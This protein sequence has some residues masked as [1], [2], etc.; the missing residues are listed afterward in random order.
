[1]TWGQ[2][3]ARCAAP[4]G[5][6]VGA[7][8]PRRLWVFVAALFVCGC[9]GG[10]LQAA[11]APHYHLRL[12]AAEPASSVLCDRA[13]EVEST[14]QPS[15]DAIAAGRD[16]NC[17]PV[18]SQTLE[19]P[20]QLTVTLENAT[21]GQTYQLDYQETHSGGS[22]AAPQRVIDE[23]V[24]RLTGFAM[25]GVSSLLDGAARTDP[26]AQG[27][28]RLG[29]REQVESVAAM[30]DGEL[31]AR[32]AAATQRVLPRPPAA[33]APPL[34]YE[35]LVTQYVEDGA[36]DTSE[37]SFSEQEPPFAR[38][39]RLDGSA[40]SLLREGGRSDD[41]VAAFVAA[42]CRRDGW[43]PLVPENDAVQ[44]LAYVSP[45]VA[46]ED[47][48]GALGLT[49][50]A[51]A[52]VLGGDGSFSIGQTI[53]ARYGDAVGTLRRGSVPEG[54]VRAVHQLAV[55][56]RLD[57]QLGVCL[58]NIDY[59]LANAT[60]APERTAAL[61]AARAEVVALQGSTRD[62]AQLYAATI[63]PFVSE[64]AATYV[65]QV[66]AE[67]PVQLGTYALRGGEVSLAVRQ[68][69]A[70]PFTRH[71]FAVREGPWV[72]V[73][74][75][76]VVTFCAS[77]LTRVEQQALPAVGDGENPETPTAA[78][79]VIRQTAESAGVAMAISLHL[80][81]FRFPHVQLGVMLGYPIGDATG[82]AATGLLGASL[83]I[84][85]IG[86]QI[87]VGA[88]FFEQRSMRA[89]FGTEVD[90]SLPDNAYLTIDAVSQTTIGVAGFAMAGVSFDVL[91]NL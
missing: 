56:A 86:L 22:S 90:L 32:I 7:A 85:P 43:G 29:G 60:L 81:V 88:Q 23:F 66:A 76:P 16:V 75:G 61:A 48:I 52:G 1:M 57:R 84:S 40:A 64:L 13:I 12:N 3:V 14:G 69:G 27:L 67:A 4:G 91:N 54:T 5:P 68:Q 51:L 70:E 73:S 49:P 63:L 30:L 26:A 78:R 11:S 74:V 36:L 59:L 2:A 17:R 15:G 55:E 37:V 24:R 58:H 6:A 9:G 71:R 28:P 38:T 44:T 8:P 31:R 39:H 89:G 45:A 72:A 80:T 41:E 62:A 46:P 50:E 25:T 87:G 20:G 33:T 79:P 42:H 18:A 65:S 19:A 82:S 35:A 77:C 47:V 10:T 34:T 83:R 21:P 53:Q